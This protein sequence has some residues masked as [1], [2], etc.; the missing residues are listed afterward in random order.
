[1]GARV[2]CI[3]KG[4]EEGI[5]EGGHAAESR[6]DIG[7]Q[8]S[9]G[10]MSPWRQEASDTYKEAIVRAFLKCFCPEGRPL[11]GSDP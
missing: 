10:T 6:R 1:M 11:A 8:S 3:P 5:R 9:G 4:E 2:G 7:P